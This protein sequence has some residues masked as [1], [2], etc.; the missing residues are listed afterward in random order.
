MKKSRELIKE[1]T[2]S[3]LTN[4]IITHYITLHTHY[5][6]TFAYFFVA[7]KIATKKKYRIKNNMQLCSKFP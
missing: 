5:M 2:K 7:S 4:N 1:H 6:Y 3:A